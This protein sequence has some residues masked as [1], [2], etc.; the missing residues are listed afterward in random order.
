MVA[1]KSIQYYLLIFILFIFTN[2]SQATAR[3]LTVTFIIPDKEGPM[4]WQLVKDVSASVSS[5]LGISFNYVHA[6]SDRFAGEKVIKEILTYKDKPDFLIFRPFKG[7][8]ESTFNL[9]ERNQLPF[10]T[11]ERAFDG[12]E[13]E[14]LKEP[15]ERYT[16][17]LGQINYDNRHGGELLASALIERHLLQNPSRR[18]EIIGIGGDFDSVST[19]RQKYLQQLIQ[20]PED[21]VIVNQVFPMNW[22]PLMVRARMNSIVNRYPKG[23]IYWSAGDQMSFEVIDYYKINK[24]PLPLVG[25]FD[26]LPESLERIAKGEMT[27][28]VGGHFLIVAQALIKLVDYANGIDRMSQQTIYNY[29]LITIENVK[30]YQYFLNQHGWKDIDYRLF[31]HSLSEQKYTLTIDKLVELYRQKNQ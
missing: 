21:S 27:A 4:F 17:W 28:S 24:L 26:W 20:Y 11:I 8:A 23:N 3:E 1:M 22:N 18:A 7:N 10:V 16:Y 14:L 13:A 31:S 6:D 15:Q 9:L 19:E 30:K 2:L 29:E 12:N 5:D 25:G